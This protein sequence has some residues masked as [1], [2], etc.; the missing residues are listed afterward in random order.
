MSLNRVSVKPGGVAGVGLWDRRDGAPEPSQSYKIAVEKNRLEW[1][2]VAGK[3]PVFVSR[4]VSASISRV[5]RDL[6]KSA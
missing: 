5:T 1:R 2:A 6:C 3:S 4:A